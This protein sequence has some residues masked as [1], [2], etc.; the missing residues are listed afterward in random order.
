MEAYE[1]HGIAAIGLNDRSHARAVG[2]LLAALNVLAPHFPILVVDGEQ[3]RRRGLQRCDERRQLSPFS[4]R[5][6]R[7]QAARQR[8]EQ[9]TAQP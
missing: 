7:R 6:E 5:D 9:P 1:S 3:Q 8:V 2:H 4:A